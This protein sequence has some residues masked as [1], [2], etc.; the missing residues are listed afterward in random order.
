MSSVDRAVLQRDGV[1]QAVR[2]AGH[3]HLL[4]SDDALHASLSQTLAAREPGQP[5]WLFAYG[6]LIWNPT[7]HFA[8]RAPARLHGYHRGFYLWSRLNRGTPEQPGLVL[9]LDRG[10]SCG[11]VAYRLDERMLGDELLLIWRREMIAG[12]YMPRWM[13]VVH[14]GRRLRAIAFVVDRGKPWY[15]PRM[16]DEAAVRV[17]ARA[18]GHYGSC[19]DYLLQTAQA[20]RDHGIRDAR[21]EALARRLHEVLDARRTP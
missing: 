2:D 5:V 17:I 6:S 13:Q 7:F 12:T 15:A 1:R 16:S 4:L 8:E 20:L 14:G 21:L 19:A 10:G 9:G 11:G 18:R 3:G